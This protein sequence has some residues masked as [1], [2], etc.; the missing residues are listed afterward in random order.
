LDRSF[1]FLY[2]SLDYILVVDID[3]T[4]CKNV[5]LHFTRFMNHI[6]FSFTSIQRKFFGLFFRNNLFHSK[7]FLFQFRN[8]WL[9][10]IFPIT[11][12]IIILLTYVFMFFALNQ[13]CVL[14]FWDKMMICLFILLNLHFETLP[15]QWRD[16]VTPVSSSYHIPA[17]RDTGM[18]YVL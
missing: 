14:H 11:F 7:Q 13:I 5:F 1:I 16:H 17:R 9:T 15:N 3:L 2:R 4:P 10:I 12:E 18:L 8:A 6:T